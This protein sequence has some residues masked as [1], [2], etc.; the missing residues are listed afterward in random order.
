MSGKFRILTTGFL[1]I[2][3]AVIVYLSLRIDIL[4]TSYI[5]RLEKSTADIT[6][7]LESLKGKNG[8]GELTDTAFQSFAA[9]LFKK[10]GNTAIVAVSDHDNNVRHV[11]KN[12]SILKTPELFDSIMN[13][14]KNRKVSAD[15]KSGPARRYYS[16]QK[17][18]TR[19]EEKFYL[20][21]RDVGKNRLF[22]AFPY[23]ADRKI[24]TRIALEVALLILISVIL[25]ALVYIVSQRKEPKQVTAGQTRGIQPHTL[26]ASVAGEQNMITG[27]RLVTSESLS[28]HV[29]SILNSLSRD[30]GSNSL[31]LYLKT[32][33][34]LLSKAYE[35]KGKTFLRIDSGN[36]DTLDLRQGL[37]QELQNNAA[38]ILNE[39]KKI[40][41]PLQH[42]NSL[43]GI[44]VVERENP[45]NGQQ[46]QDIRR[47]LGATAREISDFLVI[48]NVMIHSG[49]G[50]YSKS[51]FDMK[52]HE[53][54]AIS[55]KG[56]EPLSVM[57][58]SCIPADVQLTDSQ[59]NNVYR[60]IAPSIKEHLAARDIVAVYN[61]NLA[62]LL[63]GTGSD[64]ASELTGILENSLSRY[65]LKIDTGSFLNI[66][67]RSGSASTDTTRKG[68]DLV[69]TA[70]KNLSMAAQKQPDGKT[71]PTTVQAVEKA[72]PDERIHPESDTGMDEGSL[73]KKSERRFKTSIGL[74]LI[75]IISLIILASLTSMSIITT[76]LFRTDNE[77]RIKES[78]HKISEITA[79]N[80]RTDFTSIIEKSMIITRS[81]IDEGVTQDGNQ[82][83]V[84][85][86]FSN[87]QD[88]LF[89]GLA[90][91]KNGTLELNR[92]L[93]N[94]ALTDKNG[95][96]Q[97]SISTALMGEQEQFLKSFNLQE[98]VH[99]VSPHFS[100]PVIAISV[101]Y[102]KKSESSAE[103]ILIIMVHGDRFNRAVSNPGITK[104]FIVNGSGELIAHYNASLVSAGVSFRQFPIVKL[105]MTSPVDN[106]QTRYND[107]KNIYYL[108]SYKKT[109]FAG[110]GVISTVQEDKAFEAVNQIQRRN[111]FITVIVLSAAILIVYFFAKT[112][113]GPIKRL[114]KATRQ[115]EQGNF[116]IDITSSSGDEIGMLTESFINMGKG[117][118]EREKIK[119]AFG[120]FVNKEI[121]DKVLRDEIKLGGERKTVAIFFSDIRSFT[122]IS[123]K[124]E[125]EEV[126]EFLN[127]YMT[128]MVDCVNKTNGVVDKF[129]GDAIMATWGAPVSH[130]NDTENAINAALMMRESLQDFNRERG[131]PKKPV[132]KIGC[133]INTGPVLVGQIGSHDRMEYTV[134]GD[135]VN[136]ASRVETLN[137]PFGTDILVSEES[138]KLV[139]DIFTME[140]MHDI[141]VK[142]KFE[143]QKIY[144]VLGRRD[145]PHCAG[146][147]GELQSRLGVDVSSLPSFDP[148][149][150]EEKF[151][152]LSKKSES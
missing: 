66:S 100:I 2:F 91:M 20:Y 7:A 108:G 53:S 52:L 67:V 146:S 121:A 64:R 59:K 60:I 122:S 147:L 14:Y 55:R 78:N 39:G 49:T 130:G 69:M 35:L 103:S 150:E 37:G 13:D 34:D 5:N 140:R 111:A 61:E 141:K 95:I 89:I 70:M 144:A 99:N 1:I 8:S 113:T 72:R 123:E 82:F 133:G 139:K 109:G 30:Y 136:L 81:M 41:L 12:E 28:D 118:S 62:L 54:I 32:T 51:Y 76:K 126:V 21:I 114:V 137:K 25:M 86:F 105:M 127:E 97:N 57:L 11:Q 73:K 4:E 40:I 112:L 17:N 15:L 26:H 71:L 102:I 50:L 138:Y 47:L 48:N 84:Q 31:S 106:G 56:S 16:V 46:I 88:T 148:E 33:P 93:Y 94:T 23:Q 79:L 42:D 19:S 22:L 115:I 80:I 18:E 131:G 151:Q 65:R 27:E 36:F 75:S 152:I 68:K 85:R 58:I 10:Y 120:K 3:V 43:L 125:P 63:P 45:L 74:K 129:I 143:T 83:L 107:E 92:S 117:L 145:D 128:R 44:L 101:P 116:D 110:T 132:I 142:G 6:T 96:S 124:L 77:I 119:V 29:F 104:S 134:I 87:D 9:A 24:I 135:S 38:M 149:A 90:G 98:I